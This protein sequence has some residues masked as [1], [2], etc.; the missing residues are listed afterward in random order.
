MTKQRLRGTTIKQFTK[1]SSMLQLG[2]GVLEHGEWHKD[3]RPFLYH[4]FLLFIAMHPSQ[5]Q[6]VTV[7]AFTMS[8]SRWTTISKN[9][10]EKIRYN[11]RKCKEIYVAVNVNQ[12]QCGDN[13]QLQSATVHEQVENEE[14]YGEDGDTE[15]RCVPLA[16]HLHVD[17]DIL[18]EPLASQTRHHGLESQ[19]FK[20]NEGNEQRKVI[21]LEIP[22]VSRDS[23]RVNEIHDNRA[24]QIDLRVSP[25]L[26]SYKDLRAFENE[27]FVD[28]NGRK[29]LQENNVRTATLRLCQEELFKKEESQWRSEIISF[30]RKFKLD[31]QSPYGKSVSIERVDRKDPSNGLRIQYT[32]LL[33]NLREILPDDS[34]E[35]ITG[36]ASARAME[37]DVQKLV[38]KMAQVPIS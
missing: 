5:I 3:L 30:P 25:T 21:M 20:L 32:Y 11:L 22:Q 1:A 23:I 26:Y 37:K 16:D 34:A 4:D 14:V 17:E 31:D 12:E 6:S 19:P 13:D 15:A 35:V 24:L 38:A 36:S 9:S 18:T 27:C 28:A 10:Y 2:E 33:I 8:F 7:D 29:L